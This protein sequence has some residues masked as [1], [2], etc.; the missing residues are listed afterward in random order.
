MDRLANTQ[1]LLC[2]VVLAES[3]SFNDAATRLGL[4]QSAVS[5]C[6]KQL[7]TLFGTELVLRRTRPLKLTQAGAALKQAADPLINDLRRMNVSVREAAE[8]GVK[9]CRLGLITSLSEVF[10]SPLIVRLDNKIKKLNLRSGLTPVLIEAFQ[11]RE[12]DILVSNHPLPDVSGLERFK[13]LKDPILIATSTDL[14]RKGFHDLH[15]LNETLPLIKYGRESHIGIQC[16]V[17]L[18]RLSIL[19]QTRYET[20]ETH[21]MLNFVQ[22]GHSWAMLSA[23][24][25]SQSRDHL[26]GISALPLDGNKHFR[27]IYLV[28][29]EGEFGSIPEFIATAIQRIFHEQIHPRLL[30]S[31]PWLTA[32]LFMPEASDIGVF[33]ETYRP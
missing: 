33:S 8:K 26:R 29:R 1:Q 28:A 24:C 12:I 16:E 17:I 11:R 3:D 4:T 25:L 21:T 5:Q 31:A 10:G 14:A 19:A 9:Q 13:L 30:A 32:N 23:L 18:R 20:D 15:E 2:F 27:T 7:E 22:D 6:L